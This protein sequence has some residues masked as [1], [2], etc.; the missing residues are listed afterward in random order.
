MALTNWNDILNKPKGIDEVPEITL[1]VEQLSAS[2]LSLGEDVG[3]IAGDVQEIALEIS[4]LSASNLPFTAT[5]T[6]KQK[7]E[8]NS[9][10]SSTR[11]DLSSYNSSNQYTFPSDGYLVY[12]N[13]GA[14]YG[15]GIICNDMRVGDQFGTDVT[16][17]SGNALYVK[18]GMTYY[19]LSP[20][21]TVYFYPFS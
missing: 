19:N 20:F 13:S 1:T 7:I 14:T 6:I 18:K 12:E 21:Y 15:R 2:V 9:I 4:Q 3:E 8:E 16:K 11:V 17:T 10:S 5:Q